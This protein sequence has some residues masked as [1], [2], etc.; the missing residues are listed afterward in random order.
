MQIR[1]ECIRNFYVG[2]HVYLCVRL[3]KSSL[4]LENRA[5]ITPIYCGKFEV[6]NR[7]ELVAYRLA[8]LANIKYYDVFHISLLK[9]YVHDP[10]HLID[11]NVIEV[12]PKG[13][14][15]TKRL[16]IINKK[17]TLL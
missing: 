5:K 17:V 1:I 9:K 6:L 14:F 2:D 13:D 3:R 4:K 7:I 11:W 12:E 8:L 15:Q 16:C 10:N